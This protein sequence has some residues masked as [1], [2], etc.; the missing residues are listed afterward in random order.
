MPLLRRLLQTMMMSPRP[1]NSAPPNV[2]WSL[3]YIEESDHD[4]LLRLWAS[5]EDLQPRL[6]A[7]RSNLCRY[8]ERNPECSFLAEGPSKQLLGCIF[9][10]HDGIRGSLNHLAVHPQWRRRG[11]AR[12]LVRRALEALTAAEIAMVTLWIYDRNQDGTAFWHALGFEQWQQCSTWSLALN[13]SI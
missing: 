11:I 3:R 8:L 2:S 13:T 12:A 10:G 9:A 1:T 6:M 4:A 5:C 7:H